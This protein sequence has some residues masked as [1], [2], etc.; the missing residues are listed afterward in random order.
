MKRFGKEIITSVDDNGAKESVEHKYHEY[1]EVKPI[2]HYHEVPHRVEKDDVNAILTIF[3]DLLSDPLK[4]D[5]A[6]K[7]EHTKHG[8]AGG[9]I[10]A[11]GCYTVL[12]FK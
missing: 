5:C 11:I 1:S 10:H 6:V 2:K 8:D 4:L 7:I 9:Y 3:N 12:E